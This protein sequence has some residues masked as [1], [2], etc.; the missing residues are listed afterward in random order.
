MEKS[1][2][3]K[4]VGLFVF[5]GLAL[6]AVLLL[7]FSK[8]TSVFRRTYELRLRAV[9]VGGLKPRSSV[10]MSGVQVG[11]VSDI[12]LNPTGTDVTIFVKIYKEYTIR[13]DAQFRIEQSGFLGDQYVAIVPTKNEAEPFKDKDTAEIQEPFNLQEVARSAGGFIRRIDETAAKLN[14]AIVDVRRLVLNEETLTNLAV[15]I[16]TMRSA[17]E[18]ALST[19]DGI[20]RLFATNGPAISYAASN[21]AAFSEDLTHFADSLNE[22]VTSNRQGIATAI[23]NLES[24]SAI[25]KTLLADVQ[26]GKGPAGTL[27]R[28][29]QTAAN[30]TNIVN[31]LSVTTS[32]L[33]RLGLWGILWKKKAPKQEPQYEPLPAP[34][35]PFNK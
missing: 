2:H 3:E 17:S 13:K 25:L 15:T 12:K 24:S 23:T 6:L 4:K 29:E 22:V 20:D 9:N 1:R 21:V 7:Q 16:S 11:N 8:G 28:D 19:V 30:L 14:E 5:I 31:N 26:A 33:N 35:A 32:N 18:R 34:K 27:L 10:L